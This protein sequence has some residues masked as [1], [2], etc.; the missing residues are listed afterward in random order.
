MFYASYSI[1]MYSDYYYIY[2]TIIINFMFE[3]KL[4]TFDVYYNVCPQISKDWT[5]STIEGIV[6][7]ARCD[8]LICRKQPVSFAQRDGNFGV[9]A[10]PSPAKGDRRTIVRTDFCR[11]FYG[12]TFVIGHGQKCDLFNISFQNMLK[13]ARNISFGK[14][15]AV[16]RIFLENNR[17]LFTRRN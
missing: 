15:K 16:E 17:F 9:Q 2:C 11:Y 3:A 13:Y 6:S 5:K 10:K 7:S 14:R 12:R 1:Y 8:C 4:F